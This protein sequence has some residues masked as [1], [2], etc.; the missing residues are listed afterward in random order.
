MTNEKVGKVRSYYYT[1]KRKRSLN[2]KRVAKNNINLKQFKQKNTKLKVNTKK[3][4][5]ILNKLK[6]LKV[7][8]YYIDKFDEKGE[9]IRIYG[10]D[11][12]SQALNELAQMTSE[13][14]NDNFIFESKDFTVDFLAKN[15]LNNYAKTLKASTYETYLSMF[16]KHLKPKSKEKSILELS[17]S[18]IEDKEAQLQKELEL[19]NQRKEELRKFNVN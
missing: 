7:K 5:K 3:L 1:I 15:C 14:V 9:R 16:S 13:K 10:F 17:V 2:L 19:L 12:Q 4:K 6:L 11:K 8:K 18:E